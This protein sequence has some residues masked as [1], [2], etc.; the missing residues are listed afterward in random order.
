MTIAEFLSIS[1]I[2]VPIVPETSSNNVSEYFE[3]CI[4]IALPS[5]ESVIQW[6]NLLV[7]YIEDPD[8]VF[9]SRLYESKKTNGIWDNRRGSLTI[10]KDGLSFAFASNYFARLIYTMAYFGYVP[11]YDDF[12]NT[13]KNREI[14][15]NY[16][17]P[18]TE[19]ER[20]IA[21]YKLKAHKVNFY[22]PDWY[23]AHII[24]Y[25]DDEYIN[26]EHIK[27]EDILPLGTATDWND[28]SNGYLVRKLDYTLS[29]EKKELMKAQFLRFID[30]I[31]YFL[32]PNNSHS[33]IKS[34]GED[35][36][37]VLYMRARAQEKFGKTY[38]DFKN[39]ALVRDDCIPDIPSKFIGDE[40]ELNVKSYSNK[41]EDTYAVSSSRPIYHNSS[42]STINGDAS[43]KLTLIPSDMNEF[44]K[45]LLIKKRAKKVIVYRNGAEVTKYWDASK[46][47]PSS[48]LIN[49]IK[50]SNE[51]RKRKTDGIVEIIIE[52]V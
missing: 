23:L 11:D 38:D 45:Q 3:K 37:V 28:E 17:M 14:S 19:V 7:K 35:L 4:Q 33:S 46:Y 51:W 12:K 27:L 21:A 36:K 41:R 20:Q 9:L 10:M 30:P 48:D 24:A 26:H 16:I 2:K 8:C 40:L 43:T 50:S 5:D 22:T 32:V 42:S 47:R 6:H 31:N 1:Q 34:I 52:I 49:N 25:K 18:P 29:P 39:L 15:L 44:K 13:L